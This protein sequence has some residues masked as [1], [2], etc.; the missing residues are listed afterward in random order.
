[1]LWNKQA[2]KALTAF[3]LTFAQ[4]HLP[5]MERETNTY[6]LS[7]QCHRPVYYLESKNK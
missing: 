6:G 5:Y 2:E 3:H 4:T 1:M 7:K